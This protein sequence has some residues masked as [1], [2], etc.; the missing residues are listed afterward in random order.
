MHGVYNPVNT[1]IV[2]DL[3]MRRIDQN[4]FVILHSGILIDPVGVQ[5]TQVG[6]FASRLLLGNTLLVTLSLNL[7]NTLILGL[8]VHHTTVI[9][10][11]TSTATDTATDDDI[12][13]FGLVAET[14]GLVSTSGTV[15]AGDVGA[16][17]VFP[18]TDAEEKA[19]GITLLVTP[20]LFHVFVAT[21]FLIY[22]L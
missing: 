11:L 2:P 5:D 17:T 21:H 14:M 22:M 15:H 19:E 1:G 9:G 20:E 16:L 12:S 18:G 8:T 4:N 7:S 6:K 3:L 13:L 10:A